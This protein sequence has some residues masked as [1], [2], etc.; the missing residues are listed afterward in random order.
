MNTVGETERHTGCRGGV[1]RVG[2]GGGGWGGEEGLTII[3]AEVTAKERS[4]ELLSVSVC[5]VV[6]VA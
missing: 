6:G 1:V 3:E 5:I 2:G 4:K